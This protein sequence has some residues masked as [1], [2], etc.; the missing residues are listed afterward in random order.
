[1]KQQEKFVRQV[2]DIIEKNSLSHAYFIETNGYSDYMKAIVLFLKKIFEGNTDEINYN[3]INEDFDYPEIKLLNADGK[4]IKKEQIIELKKECS[5]APV[6]GKYIVY[7]INGAEFLNQ[8]SANTLLKFL[9]EPEK[10]IIGILVSNSRYQVINTL[11]SRCQILSLVPDDSKTENK[12][13]VV[14]FVEKIKNKDYKLFLDNR[15]KYNWEREQ[16][17]VFLD[18][19]VAYCLSDSYDIIN[20][21]IADLVEKRR[22]QMRF[23]VNTKLFMDN[24]VLE[25][26]EVVKCIN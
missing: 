8:S 5:K 16:L 12:G 21:S 15:D 11:I 17:V 18:Q 26:I 9:E 1:M 22:Q 13:E 19:V 23:N 4:M 3:L 20:M 25:L 14:E 7:I 24:L 6:L 2:T 10:N